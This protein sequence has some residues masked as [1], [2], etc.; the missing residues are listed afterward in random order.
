MLYILP[1]ISA[2]K[3]SSA[4]ADVAWGE[5]WPGVQGTADVANAEL[6]LLGGASFERSMADFQAAVAQLPFPGGEPTSCLGPLSP[7]SLSVCLGVARLVYAS[8]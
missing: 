5:Q 7:P 6:R 8:I 2:K 4:D 3:W 1:V